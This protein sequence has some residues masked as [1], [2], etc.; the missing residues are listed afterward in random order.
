M[1]DAVPRSIS[2]RRVLGAAGAIVLGAVA[3]RRVGAVDV[4]V[5]G[6]RTRPHTLVVRA[7]GRDG[8][9]Q[10]S[11][12]GRAYPDGTSGLHTIVALVKTV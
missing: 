7:E 11:E 9:M 3:A 10:R 2:R 8:V 4:R 6:A 12:T 5:D 1:S